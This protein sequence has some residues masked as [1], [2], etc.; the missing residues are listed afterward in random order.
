MKSSAL[1]HV[2]IFTWFVKKIVWYKM[3]STKSASPLSSGSVSSLLKGASMK[4]QISAS[5]DKPPDGRPGMPAMRKSQSFSVRP[6]IPFKF[7]AALE[8]AGLNSA[9]SFNYDT[10]RSDAKKFFT[11]SQFGKYYEN[12]MILMSLISCLEYIYETYLH[13]SDHADMRRL[14]ILNRVELGFACFFSWDWA[15]S[16]YLS[17]HRTLYFLRLVSILLRIFSSQNI[18]L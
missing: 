18:Y 6:Q 11:Q 9:S 17:E 14:Y 5:G 8:E 12:F 13:H 15:L 16:L 3:D 2:G 1:N 4:R 10:W 7:S